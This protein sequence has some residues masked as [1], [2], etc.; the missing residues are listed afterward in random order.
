V[1]LKVKAYSQPGEYFGELALLEPGTLRKATVRAS[2]GGCRVLMLDK[3]TFDRLLGPLANKMKDQVG[4]YQAYDQAVA[5][6]GQQQQQQNG[7]HAP[8]PVAPMPKAAEVPPANTPAQGQAGQPIP[9][10]SPAV[11][12]AQTAATRKGEGGGNADCT[13]LSCCTT[14]G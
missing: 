9:P 6:G 3:E 5:G 1:L 11:Q 7:G 10:A 14:M 4:G 8:A 13:F 12:T 2:P